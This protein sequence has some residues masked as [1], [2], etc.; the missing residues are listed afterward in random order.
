LIEVDW[1]H[2]VPFFA[3][4]GMYNYQGFVGLPPDS[5]IASD[6]FDFEVVE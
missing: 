2:T 5:L 3:P 6:A 1:R 4:L